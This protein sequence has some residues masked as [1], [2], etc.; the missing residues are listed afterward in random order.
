MKKIFILSALLTA[1]LLMSGCVDKFLD[2]KP[3]KSTTVVIETGEHLYALLNNYN[4]FYLAYSPWMINGT[5]DLECSTATYAITGSNYCD[6]YLPSILCYATWNTDLVPKQSDWT[7]GS[8]YTKIFYANAILENADKVSGLTDSERESIKRE[9]RFIRAYD[10]WYLAQTYCLPYISGNEDKQGLVLKTS[11]QFDEPLKRATLKETYDFIEA[12]LAEALKIDTPL[13][14]IPGTQRWRSF[15]ASKAAVNGFAARYYF[16]LNDYTNAL[17]YADLALAAHSDLVDYNTEMS[18]MN[19]VTVNVGGRTETIL[20]PYTFNSGYGKVN[21]F[22]FEWK[23]FM[24]F[25]M[26]EDHNWWYLPSESLTSLYDQTYDLRFKYHFI[27]NY[28]CYVKSMDAR[29]PAY[30]FFWKDRLPGGP[31]TPEMLLIKAEC[32]ARAGNVSAAMATVN[33]LRAVRMDKSAPASVINLTASSKEEAVK[34]ILEERRREMPFAK[35]LWDIRRLN[36]NSDSF[37]DV[38]DITKTF[39]DFDLNNINKSVTKTYTLGKND[40]KIACPIP[41]T[42]IVASDGVI[43]QNRY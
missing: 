19:P 40:P 37:D 23:E 43:E 2:V 41:E 35:R 32:E 5:D 29:V 14:K 6:V 18:Y 42:E 21:D 36:Y 39:Y 13:E 20:L 34:K 25:R 11:T 38:G 7:W 28:S 26:E 22:M 9:A 1:S 4:N 16:Y 10:L 17:K 30:V 12:D 3:S 8:E 31:T 15:R 27:P 24:Y 33:R